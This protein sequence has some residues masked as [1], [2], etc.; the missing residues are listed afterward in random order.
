MVWIVP[1]NGF[2]NVEMIDWMSC[3]MVGNVMISGIFKVRRKYSWATNL[4]QLMIHHDISNKEYCHLSWSHST[5]KNSDFV[6]YERDYIIFMI[7]LN[8]R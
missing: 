4:P 3:W 8:L 1:L 6:N 5:S 7:C 2:I